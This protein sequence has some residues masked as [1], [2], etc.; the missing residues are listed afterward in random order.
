MKCA[1]CGKDIEKD[2]TYYKVN[3][4]FLLIKYFD[5]DEDSIFC[6]Q[7]CICEALSIDCLTCEEQSETEKEFDQ[8][9]NKEEEYT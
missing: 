1:N 6:S 8:I 2:E 3:D 5:T 7:E 4:N 9:I